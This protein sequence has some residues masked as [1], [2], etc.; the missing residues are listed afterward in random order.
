[1][2]GHEHDGKRLVPVVGRGASNDGQ[3]I[4][5]VPVTTPSQEHENW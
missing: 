5:V 3:D 2:S 4:L 1:M